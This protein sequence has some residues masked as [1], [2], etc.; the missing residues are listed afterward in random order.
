[1]LLNKCGARQRRSVSLRI[2]WIAKL[3]NH[4]KSLKRE[5]KLFSDIIIEFESKLRLNNAQPTLKYVIKTEI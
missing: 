2:L 5:N 4:L 3:R 1:M